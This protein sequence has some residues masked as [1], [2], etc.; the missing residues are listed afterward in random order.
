MLDCVPDSVIMIVGPESSGQ[1][2]MLTA[3]LK[4]RPGVVYCN[5]REVPFFFFCK[6]Q[7]VPELGWKSTAKNK[8]TV[9]K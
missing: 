3:A 4:N 6:Y 8:K 5:M 7:T 9:L 1:T 2:A